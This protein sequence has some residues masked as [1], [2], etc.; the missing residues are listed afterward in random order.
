MKVNNI[1][2]TSQNSCSCGSWLQHW[3]NFSGQSVPAYCPE[4]KC[5]ERPEVGAHVQKD[6]S[7]DTSWYIVPLCKTHNAETGKSLTVSDSIT[8]VS[9]NVSRTCG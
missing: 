2:G 7:S 1:N 6:G 9:A 3:K 5:H 8:L 4:Q